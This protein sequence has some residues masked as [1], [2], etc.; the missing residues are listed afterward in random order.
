MSW[1]EWLFGPGSDAAPAPGSRLPEASGFP[2]MAH[3]R[4]GLAGR[5]SPP[6]RAAAG[7]PRA[8][9]S[10]A[11]EAGPLEHRERVYV[12][13]YDLGQNYVSKG[14]NAVAKRYGAFHSAVEVYGYE[15]SFGLAVNQWST[16][17]SWHLPG[18]N[19]DHSFRETL[20]MGTTP[21][22]SQEVLK[23]IQSMMGEWRGCTYDLFTR[24][25]HTFSDE[26]CCKLTGVPLP[27][28]VNALAGTGDAA[29]SY[30]CANPSAELEEDTGGPAGVAIRDRQH[31]AV[32]D[33]F[34]ML[35]KGR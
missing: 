20:A 25:C 11:T 19:A 27:S 34:S 9:A 17:I 15:W 8:R 1:H 32:E 13:V 23:L 29:L 28:W 21:Y 30:M 16:G 31:D 26:L 7:V 14:L 33:P 18:Q 5:G 10:D 4:C 24:N 35:R 2:P 12:R 3:R 22:S 6:E